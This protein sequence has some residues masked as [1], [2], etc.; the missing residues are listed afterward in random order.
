MAPNRTDAASRSERRKTIT[1]VKQKVVK[2]R[3]TSTVAQKDRG[4]RKEK[5]SLNEEACE[6]SQSCSQ[7]EGPLQEENEALTGD[8][9]SRSPLPFPPTPPP[10]TSSH[11]PGGAQCF[12][13]QAAEH[14]PDLPAHP[15][16]YHQGLPHSAQN[17]V[18]LSLPSSDHDVL[19]HQAH[20][21]GRPA[22]VTTYSEAQKQFYP[23]VPH[24]EQVQHGLSS[25]Q[26]FRPGMYRPDDRGRLHSSAPSANFHRPGSSQS[27]E[28]SRPQPQSYSP[29][30]Q[31]EN[32]HTGD[33]RS[34]STSTTPSSFHTGRD[35]QDDEP[36]PRHCFITDDLVGARRKEHSQ[37]RKATSGGQDFQRE[38]LRILHIIRL[39]VEHHTKQLESIAQRSAVEEEETPVLV[40]PCTSPDELVEFD[41]VLAASSDARS[42][43]KRLLQS[44]GGTNAK[45]AARRM[46]ST[47]MTDA[48]A[49]QF[50][51]E[52]KNDKQR[53]CD[54]NCTNIILSCFTG[55]TKHNRAQGTKREAEEAIRSWLRH[56]S[57]RLSRSSAS[58]TPCEED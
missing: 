51:W 58:R 46:M 7:K 5:T 29:G 3:P 54:L 13:L 9:Y 10:M 20:L 17:M 50:T 42:K 36:A 39:T 12:M 15:Q 32:Y 27:Y 16:H 44:L 56:A 55:H 47:L 26:Y 41:N 57:E 18:H 40:K 49:A 35:A 31:T 38:I 37:Q 21:Q 1:N 30:M 48:V 11:P 14:R 45:D 8:E 19:T 43:L 24:D 2:R 53:L 23:T 25:V 22:F 28:G 4:R 33:I 34:T 6:Q 52:G